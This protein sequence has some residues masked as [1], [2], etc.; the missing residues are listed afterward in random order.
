MAFLSQKSILMLSIAV[1]IGAGGCATFAVMEDARG[2]YTEEQEVVEF[3][4]QVIAIGRPSQPIAEYP[5]AMVLAGNKYSFLV[6]PKVDAQTPANLFEQIFTQVDL[7]ALY[8][9][10]NPVQQQHYGQTQSL[11]L[12]LANGQ[13]EIKKLPHWIG[14][15]FTKPTAQLGYGEQQRLELFGFKCNTVQIKQQPHLNCSRNVQTE[16]TLAERVNN[17]N[18]LQYKLKQPLTVKMVH[19]YTVEKSKVGAKLLLLP[20]AVSLDIITLPLQLLGAIAVI[21]N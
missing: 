6:Q 16:F 17:F 7:K 19:T 20:V 11:T 3:S 12:K 13:K 14:L 5:H 4:E 10:P 15:T 21:S 1:C 9:N 18:Q 8:I 2:T